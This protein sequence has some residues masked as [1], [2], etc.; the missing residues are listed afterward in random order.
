MR[1]AHEPSMLC[2][3]Y[4]VFMLIMFSLIAAVLLSGCHERPIFQT[5]PAIQKYSDEFSADLADRIAPL[6]FDDPVT[7]VV[8]DY[9]AERDKLC[10]CQTE[11]KLVEYCA[12][13]RAEE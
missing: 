3:A 11:P 10:T 13:R 2:R 1:T 8:A 12:R 4:Y 5:C 7:I 9:M 6:P